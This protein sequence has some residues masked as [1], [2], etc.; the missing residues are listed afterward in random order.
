MQVHNGVAA[1]R[2]LDGP[3][4]RQGSLNLQGFVDKKGMKNQSFFVM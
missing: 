1:H 3:S 4:H 2:K